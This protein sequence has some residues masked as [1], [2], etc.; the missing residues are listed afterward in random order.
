[1]IMDSKYNLRGPYAGY[2]TRRDR[3]LTASERQRDLVSGQ[4]W[5]EYIEFSSESTVQ[6][7]S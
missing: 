1:M 7:L 5:L 4:F 2:R 6:R 3:L